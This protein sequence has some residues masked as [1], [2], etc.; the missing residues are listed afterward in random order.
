M[1]YNS[2]AYLA[3]EIGNL[4]DTT[5]YFPMKSAYARP[6]A[7]P[8]RVSGRNREESAKVDFHCRV[9]FTCV[10]RKILLAQIKGETMYGKS[11]VNVK[12]ERR[13]TF[14]FTSGLSYI[15]SISF[16]PVN[17]TCVRTE[18]VSDSAGNQP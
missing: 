6:S 2:G 5:I 9:T 10:A 14:M 4:S 3:L 7:R 16:T 1:G 11:R 17:F 13:S 15:V 12:V 8:Y 18:K